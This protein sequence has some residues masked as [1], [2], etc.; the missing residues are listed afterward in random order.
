MSLSLA[1]GPSVFMGDE[2]PAP[3]F[4]YRSN[5]DDTSNATNYSFASCDLG[6]PHSSRLIVVGVKTI[7]STSVSSMTIGGIAATLAI[8]SGSAAR[9]A[10][11]WYALVPQGLTGTIAVNGSGASTAMRIYVWAGYPSSATPVAA[12]GDNAASASLAIANLAKTSGGFSCFVSGENENAT[13]G[14]LT[15]TGAETVTEDHEAS[16]DGAASTAAMSHINTATTTTDDYTRTWSGTN[17]RG[18]AGA[19]WA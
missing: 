5:Y 11:L 10:E 13:T 15:Q 4:S 17:G 12:I 7:G 8:T 1:F 18:I 3:A 16:L 2:G 9:S 6:T 19:T 14:T